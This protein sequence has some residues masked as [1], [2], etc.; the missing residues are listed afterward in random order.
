M[1]QTDR[2]ILDDPTKL[3][4]LYEDEGLT[5]REI[6]RLTGTLAGS[7]LYSLRFHGIKTRQSK[8]HKAEPPPSTDLPHEC[9]PRKSHKKQPARL[10]L[11]KAVYDQAPIKESL[12][13]RPAPRVVPVVLAPPSQE[14]CKEK[15]CPFPAV[16]GAQ[17]R[18]HY[19]DTLTA[20][21]PMGCSA[22]AIMEIAVGFD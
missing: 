22:T 12:A 5:M 17:C 10:L 21:S 19:V 7:V 15:A 8:S 2:S 14:R 3:R 6:G 1:L 4:H 18:K 20:A 9:F 11:R 16:V 13:E